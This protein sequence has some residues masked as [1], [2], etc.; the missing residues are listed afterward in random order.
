MLGKSLACPRGKTCRQRETGYRTVCGQD[1]PAGPTRFIVKQPYSA[2]R[3]QC[4]RTGRQTWIT[5]TITVTTYVVTMAGQCLPSAGGREEKAGCCH[6]PTRRS[7]QC[8][9]GAH[10][11]KFSPILHTPPAGDGLQVC[12]DAVDTST[13]PGSHLE[14]ATGLGHSAPHQSHT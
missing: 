10:L 8:A 13:Y 5:R 7:V 14:Q 6:G 3:A 1:F 12:W 4:C 2:L 11:C 9:R